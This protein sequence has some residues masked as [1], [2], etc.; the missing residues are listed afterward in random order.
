MSGGV[1]NWKCE[2]TTCICMFTLQIAGDWKFY[3]ECRRRGCK[4]AVTSF[5]LHDPFLGSQILSAGNAA[6]ILTKFIGRL[7]Y[8]R[9]SFWLQHR[10]S[11]QPINIINFSSL[12]MECGGVSRAHWQIETY[13]KEMRQCGGRSVL[14]IHIL[15]CLY[16]CG[17]LRVYLYLK[18]DGC[19]AASERA[20]A[21]FL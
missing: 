18:R 4:S 3:E 7:N 6:T 11:A 2:I 10:T 1:A 5:P 12:W 13:N 15:P 17:P 14:P 21:C 19:N 8:W 9:E 16:L 20:S